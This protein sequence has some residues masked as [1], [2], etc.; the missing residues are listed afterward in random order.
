MLPTSTSWMNFRGRR[1]TADDLLEFF[2]V[3]SAPVN[4]FE[5]ARRLGVRFTRQKHA[6]HSGVV[7][8]SETGDATII[9][10][11][12]DSPE[13]QRFTLAHEIGHLLLHPIGKQ[14]RDD[15]YT[16]TP[17][18]IEANNFASEL[19]MPDALLDVAI[20]KHG[21]EPKILASLFKVSALSMRVRLMKWVQL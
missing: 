4:V 21:T 7:S 20:M 3:T 6:E 13:R 14:F 16:G 10:K 17:Q 19:L 18:E 12:E 2:G 15:S 11:A 8:S 1:A 5:I 9:V